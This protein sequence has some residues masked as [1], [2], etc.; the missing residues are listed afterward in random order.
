MVIRTK[1]EKFAEQNRGK[2]ESIKNIRTEDLSSEGKG[3]VT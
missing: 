2:T 1:P 3:K